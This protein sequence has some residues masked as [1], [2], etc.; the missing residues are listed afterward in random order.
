MNE[1]GYARFDWEK[2]QTKTAL[3]DAAQKQ[4]KIS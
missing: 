2:S 4:E 1:Q 3:K